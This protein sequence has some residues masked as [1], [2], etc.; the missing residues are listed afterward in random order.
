LKIVDVN[1]DLS[2]R[3]IVTA[4]VAASDTTN[5]LEGETIDGVEEATGNE[6][7]RTT[8]TMRALPIFRNDVTLQQQLF[9]FSFD[10]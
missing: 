4:A 6:R 5:D 2:K 8:M 10:C 9:K 1:P 3:H 7:T